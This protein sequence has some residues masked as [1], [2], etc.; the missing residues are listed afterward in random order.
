MRSGEDVTV[1]ITYH[2]R[3]RSARRRRFVLI[4]SLFLFLLELR[5]CVDVRMRLDSSNCV[6]LPGQRMSAKKSCFECGVVF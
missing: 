4:Q 6:K 3:R 5:S 2:R 1:K